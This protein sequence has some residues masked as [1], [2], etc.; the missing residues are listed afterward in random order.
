MSAFDEVMAESWEPAEGL[1][2]GCATVWRR[3]PG[4]C[5]GDLEVSGPEPELAAAIAG[6]SKRALFFLLNAIPGGHSCPNCGERDRHKDWCE[7]G[8]IVAEAKRIRE[9]A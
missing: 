3:I 7:W 1:A 4:G 5:A 9:G 6:L 2:N 8:D